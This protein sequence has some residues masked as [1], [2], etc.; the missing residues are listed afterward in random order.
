MNDIAVIVKDL[1]ALSIQKK[2]TIST[3]ESCT[4]GL[5]SKYI[6]DQP[7]SSNF[8]NSSIIAYSNESK[9]SLLHVQSKT[10][11]EK[12]A[13]SEETVKEMAQGLLQITGSSVVIAVSGV[14][15]ADIDQGSQENTRVWFCWYNLDKF[16]TLY[17]R[18]HGDR[19]ENRLETTKTGLLG[20]YD[21]IKEI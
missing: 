1:M 7:G 10:I 21:F 11:E 14:M 17:K 13:V 19:R 2:I 20:L 15:G 9:I 8:F 3:A 18:L 5:I 6:T 12:G 4:G 16:K